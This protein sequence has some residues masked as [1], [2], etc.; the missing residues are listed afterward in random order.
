MRKRLK[1][2][3]VSGM[4]FIR[5]LLLVFLTYMVQVTVM[6]YLRINDVAASICYAVIAIVTVCYG[7]T[8]AYWTGAIFGILFETMMPSIMYLNLFLWPLTALF[9]SVFFADRS[10][11]RLEELR[12]TNPNARN[13]NVYIRTVACALLNVL[14]YET[15]NIIYM[16]L[17][18]TVLGLNHILRSFTNL[19]FTGALT[20]ALMVPVRRY[21]GFKKPKAEER[22]LGRWQTA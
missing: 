18:G 21:L 14:L 4:H 7:K 22:E 15:V 6:P 19:I 13:G 16:Y 12:S 9:C 2:L 11:K 17:G 1:A 8:R 10:E 3:R 5:Y 20:A